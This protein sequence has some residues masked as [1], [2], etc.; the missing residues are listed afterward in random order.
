[1]GTVPGTVP[2]VVQDTFARATFWPISVATFPQICIATPAVVPA[3]DCRATPAVTDR[4]I[5]QTTSI[6]T[7]GMSLRPT[8][9]MNHAAV[10]RVVVR[11]I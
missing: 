5:R 6:P 4:L 11:P 2:K 9:T 10:C 7:L 1:M 3:C 8:A